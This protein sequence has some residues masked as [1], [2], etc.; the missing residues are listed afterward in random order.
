MEK[1]W[2]RNSFPTNIYVCL[3][4][5][6]LAHNVI[7]INGSDFWRAVA[8]LTHVPPTPFLTHFP[9]YYKAYVCSVIQSCPTVCDPMDHSLPGSSSMGFLKNTGVGCHFFLQG[10]SLA[11]GLNPCL[12]HLLHWHVDSLPLEPPKE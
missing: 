4:Y 6:C 12:L 10:I 7:S 2:K 8:K 9:L 5:R 1:C 11:Q 3:N